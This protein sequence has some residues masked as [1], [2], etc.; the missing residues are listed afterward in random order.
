MRPLKS[1]LSPVFL[2]SSLWASSQKID[3]IY[4]HLYTDSLKKGQYNYINVDGK[5]EN[6]KW[7][8]LGEKQILL[9][10][11]LARFVGN[12]LI[13]PDDFL[14]LKVIIRAALKENPSVTIERTVWIKQKPD[15]PLPAKEDGSEKFSPKNR[16]NRY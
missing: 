14:P 9:S 16:R 6:G 15:P 2:L 10:C 4:F 1:I 7:I 12:E 5:L 8:P 13:I 3:S 11:E